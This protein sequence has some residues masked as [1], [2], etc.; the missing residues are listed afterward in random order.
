MGGVLEMKS[1]GGFELLSGVRHE[2]CVHNHGWNFQLMKKSTVGDEL[3]S[4]ARH[5]KNASFT[6]QHFHNHGGRQ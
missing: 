4:G 6:A 3:V 2:K 1:A 5:E